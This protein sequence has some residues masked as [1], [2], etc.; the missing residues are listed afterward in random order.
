MGKVKS[1][2]KILCLCPTIDNCLT[3]QLS[4]GII[5]A[6]Q[7]SCLQVLRCLHFDLLLGEFGVVY[8]ARLQ[9][10]LDAATEV[11][12]VKTLKGIPFGHYFY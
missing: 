2:H 1:T 11:V 5:D 9:W 12:A 8:K 3:S 6:V 10:H 4:F 7:A